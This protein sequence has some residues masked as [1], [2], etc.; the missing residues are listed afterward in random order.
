M[1][2]NARRLALAAAMS[3]IALQALGTQADAGV[4]VASGDEWT[5][6]NHAFATPYQAGT[7]AFVR[8]LATTFG[9]SN[10]LLLTGNGN[11]SDSQLSQLT[12][13]FTALGKSIDS[14]TGFDTS[15]LGGYDA[16]FHF[17]QGLS[18]EQLTHLDSYLTGGGNAYVSLG[19]GWYG[20]AA[21]EA[22]TW[23]PFLANYGLVAGSTWFTATGFV[24]ATVTAGPVG[25]TNLIWGYG[26][27]IERLPAGQGVS[28]VRGSF[29]GGPADVGLVGASRALGVSAVPEPGSWALMILGVG[30]TGLALRR[31]TLS[32][33]APT[34][35]TR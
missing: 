2:R 6:S 29:A 17:G 10:Y 23:N 7:M 26:Q 3:F 9:G 15:T 20:T 31:R 28:Y 35:R 33:P 12:A 16:V 18:A 32:G 34:L 30:L 27:S 14:S 1:N 22:A 5:L 8:D 25:A 19:A 4:L 13:E 11:V 21:G 24:D